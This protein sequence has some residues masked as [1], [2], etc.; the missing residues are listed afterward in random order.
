MGAVAKLKPDLEGALAIFGSA[1]L[2]A[3]LMAADLIDEFVLMIHPIVLGGGR[4]LFA[5]GQS[6]RLEL[7]D[8]VA[9]STGVV[10]ATYAAQDRL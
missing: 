8:S 5:P 1:E 10:I 2:V 6:A 9:T 3:S 4:R 7:I